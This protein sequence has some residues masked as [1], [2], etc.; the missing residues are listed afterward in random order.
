MENLGPSIA[1]AAMHFSWARFLTAVA[2][3]TAL[4]LALWMLLGFAKWVFTPTNQQ[5]S[6]KGKNN[7]TV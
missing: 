1:I 2:Q 6:A 5:K 3:N 7:D 4:L